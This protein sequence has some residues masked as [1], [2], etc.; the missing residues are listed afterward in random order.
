LDRTYVGRIENL[1][2]NPTLSTLVKI[3]KAFDIEVWELL[4]FD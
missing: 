3:A 4:K 2:R 1:K